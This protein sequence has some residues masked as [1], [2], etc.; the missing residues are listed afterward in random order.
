ML[1]YQ[2]FLFLLWIFTILMVKLNGQATITVFGMKKALN[3]CPNVHEEGYRYCNALKKLLENDQKIIDSNF[4]V[5]YSKENSSNKSGD[6]G[7]T[8]R[9]Y[10]LGNKKF[11]LEIE[12]FYKNEGIIT[13]EVERNDDDTLVS[14]ILSSIVDAIIKHQAVLTFL[15]KP[16]C[17]TTKI[18]AYKGDFPYLIP[19]LNSIAQGCKKETP[20]EQLNAMDKEF[21]GLINVSNFISAYYY[22]KD[23]IT[24]F[25]NVNKLSYQPAKNL[26]QIKTEIT[27][28]AD[29]SDTIYFTSE[30]ALRFWWEKVLNEEWRGIFNK[31]V[32]KKQENYPP[33]DE[34]LKGLI[35]M[36]TINL[37][38][39]KDLEGCRYMKK[40]KT[41]KCCGISLNLDDGKVNSIMDKLPSDCK[42][43]L[44]EH[45]NY[46]GKYKGKIQELAPEEC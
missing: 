45:K 33:T 16:D 19:Q 4:T 37:Y 36:T 12:I 10:C 26:E 5:S 43:M 7:I 44:I 42:L 34:E 39:N 20:E 8:G 38:N 11:K 17:D 2:F 28:A 46:K 3:S 15:K 1:K 22:L 25:V 18:A 24:P 21:K 14:E 41:I 23:S 13:K 31:D 6:Y 27:G 29:K 9:Y 35:A 40:L 30:A 32:F